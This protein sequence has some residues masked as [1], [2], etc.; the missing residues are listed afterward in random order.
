MI[1]VV[2]F[3]ILTMEVPSRGMSRPALI[4][5]KIF[6]VSNMISS[7]GKLVI[8]GII[9]FYFICTE[10]WLYSIRILCITYYLW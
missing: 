7:M 3:T 8:L 4:R 2:L 5:M 1:I 10:N 9:E 6:Y